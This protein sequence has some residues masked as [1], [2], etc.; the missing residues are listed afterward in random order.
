MK[1]VSQEQPFACT[2]KLTSSNFKLESGWEGGLKSNHLLKA[3]SPDQLV[4]GFTLLG[5][6]NF[7]RQ[8]PHNLSVPPDSLLDSPHGKKVLLI[9]SLNLLHFNLGQLSPIVLPCTTAKSRLPGIFLVASL[10]IAAG[11]CKVPLHLSL[12]QLP[13]PFLTE[14]LI[15]LVTTAF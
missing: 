14:P 15:I 7:K 11:C 4:Q 12:F 2:G 8:R 1:A 6:E 10:Q 3:G 5:P 13:Q 9:S